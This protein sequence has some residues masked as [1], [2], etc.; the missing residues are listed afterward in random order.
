MHQ[1]FSFVVVA[2]LSVSLPLLAKDIAVHGFVTEVTSATSFELD[3][4]KVTS[5]QDLKIDLDLPK[6]EKSLS[7]FKPED[8]RVGTELE[9]SGDY[10]EQSGELK[11]KSIKVFFDDTRLVKRTALIEQVPSLTKS[12]SGWEGEIRADGEK[13]D[14]LPT[15]VVTIRPDKSE[16]KKLRSEGEHVEEKA[17]ISLDAVNLD[18]FVHYEGTRRPDGSI[19]AKTVEFQHA[20]LEPGEEKLWKNLE[21]SIKDPNYS[22]LVPGELMM[23]SCVYEWCAHVII[24]SQEVQNY[25]TQVGLSL[26]PEHQKDLPADDPRKI[27]FRFYVVQAKN[28]NAVSYPNGLVLV[29][30]GVFDV[31]QNEAQLAFVLAH[32]ISHAVEKHAWRANEYHR[33]ELIA[34]RAGGAFVPFAGPLASDLTASAIKSA[35][36]RSLENQAD[37]VALEWMLTAGYDIREAPAS[38]KAVSLKKKDGPVNPIWG[39]HDNNTMRRSYL[40]AE[41]RN[42]YSDLDYSK[43]RKDSDQFH[44]VAKIVNDFEDKKKTKVK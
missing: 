3:D 8:I 26:I 25:I 37:R 35:Y 24:P 36:V 21:P 11:A 17:L 32:E 7:S 14:V 13:I 33:K 38:W 20:E 39:S 34:L 31:L 5:K 9:V 1:R 40:M 18:T 10:D 43:L 19:E 29:N 15:T 22:S 27:P 12:G 28:F 4:Y 41:L 30:S 2:V 16:K 23:P 6:G 44:Q 42:N